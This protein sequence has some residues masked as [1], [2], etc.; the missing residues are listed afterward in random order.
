MSIPLP[1][2]LLSA[3]AAGRVSNKNNDIIGKLHIS[4]LSHYTIRHY[5]S[6]V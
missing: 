2:G 1:L 5:I 6:S 4:L 3:P